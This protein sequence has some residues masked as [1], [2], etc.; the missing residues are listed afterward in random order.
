MASY[1]FTKECLQKDEK[2]NLAQIYQIAIDLQKTN[3]TSVSNE[4]FIH[5]LFFHILKKNDVVMLYWIVDK[6]D[7]TTKDFWRNLS[8]QISTLLLIKRYNLKTLYVFLGLM[9]GNDKMVSAIQP[10]VQP[11]HYCYKEI[12][13]NICECEKV[14]LNLRSVVR[15]LT[16]QTE[17]FKYEHSKA[18]VFVLSKFREP[19][20]A[21]L[22][23][24]GYPKAYVIH[25]FDFLN[26]LDSSKRLKV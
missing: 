16:P 7:V 3:L 9:Q 10:L 15:G 12:N 19:G 11:D 21:I 17:L 8:I 24:V 14:C 25:M 4:V 5:D 18:V 26:K 20:I 23:M 1:D 2:L 13:I 22:E 6:V